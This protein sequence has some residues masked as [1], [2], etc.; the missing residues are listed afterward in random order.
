MPN[1]SAYKEIILSLN[2]LKEKST[3]YEENWAG[4][5]LKGDYD[6]TIFQKYRD[7]Y[8]LLSRLS[9]ESFV[10]FWFDS[11]EVDL[12]GVEDYESKPNSYFESKLTFNKQGLLEKSFNQIYQSFFLTSDSCEKWLSP[13]NPLDE[14]SPLN[15]FSPLYI[16]VKDLENKI[17]NDI[18]ALVPFDFDVKLL[19]I[20]PISYLPTI[21]SIK[22]SVHFISD[23]K[24]SFNLNTYA[25]EAADYDSKLGRAMLKQ[26]SIIL[27]IS[28]VDEFYDFDK[29]IL[30]GLRRLSLPVYDASDNCTYQ[31]VGSLVQ[32]VKWIYEDRVNTRKKLFNERLTLEADDSKTLIKALQL[33]LGDSLEQAKERYNFVILD[34]KDAYVKEL[35]DLLKDLRAQSDLYSQKIRGLLSNF[36]RDVLAALVLVG[37][38][39]FTKFT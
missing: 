13:L 20:Q 35:K 1:V 22:E 15:R 31:F 16:Y 7:I 24:T 38:T 12:D 33:H 9:C 19:P 36:L 2:N 25:L 34:R 37:F 29:V 10:K 18:L 28:I 6:N 21:K 4:I 8:G 39:I 11:D 14:N 30:N 26:S 3:Y 32:L 5:E 17:G 23:I 27:S